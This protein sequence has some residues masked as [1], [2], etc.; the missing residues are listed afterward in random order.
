MKFSVQVIVHPDDDTEASPVVRE[1]FTAGPRRPGSGHPRPAARGGEGPAGSGA[2]HRGRTAGQRR[3]HQAGGLPGLRRAAPAQGHPHDRG[4]QPVRQRCGCAS[5]RWW[6]CGCRDQPARDLPA[7]WPGCCPSGPPRSW[8]TCRPASPPWSPTGITADLL[9]ELLPLGRRLHAGRGAPHSPGGRP[10]AWKTSSA[11]NSP[12]SSTPAQRD[13]EELPRPDL[14]IVVGL[15]GGYVHSSQQRS[16][17]DGWFEVIAGKAIPADGRPACFGYV[18]T[19]D[20]KPKRRL[21]EV[22]RC[23]GHARPTSRSPSS[24]TAAKTSATCRCYLNA[25][26]EHLL[27]W[28]HLTMRITVMAN[29]AKSLPPPPPRPGVPGRAAGRPR[30]RDRHAAAAA[31]VVLLAR[32]R[33]PRPANRRRPDLR[34][35]HHRSRCPRAGPGCSRRSASSTATSRANAGRI[36]NYGERQRAGE[37]ISTAF[38]ESA[39]NQVDQQAHGQETADALDTPRRPPATPGPHPRPQR[40]ARRRLPPLVPRPQPDTGPHDARSVASPTLSRSLPVGD[41]G[42]LFPSRGSGR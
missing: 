11:R 37:A 3:D 14:P 19:Y 10:S 40:P 27:D 13:R 15:D 31:E 8:P 17:R 6:H 39:V 21:F 22:L 30:Q 4:A 32:Q 1:V 23:P 34:P 18:Q 24:P 33:L 20:T 41:L 26:A 35:R 29:M 7:R 5:P 38:T 12:A 2:G 28:F 25:Q 16:R 36:P 42:D 9:G